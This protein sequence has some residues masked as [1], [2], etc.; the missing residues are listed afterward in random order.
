MTNQ[1]DFDAFPDAHLIDTQNDFDDFPDARLIDTQIDETNQSFS[2]K[3]V[4]FII[5]L[6]TLTV[7]LCIFVIS[8]VLRYTQKQ[9][10]HSSHDDLVTTTIFTTLGK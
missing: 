7:F 2:V 6:V 4:L 8:M 3:K 5:V 10:K 9:Q 1:N